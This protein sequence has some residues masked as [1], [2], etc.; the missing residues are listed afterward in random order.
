MYLFFNFA[1][2]F[3]LFYSQSHQI[4]FIISLEQMYQM[5]LTKK[6][7]Q[8]QLNNKHIWIRLLNNNVK[9]N[10]KQLITLQVLSTELKTLSQEKKFCLLVSQFQ[11]IVE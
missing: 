9:N 2:D 10:L 1:T 5:K 6:Q 4:Q 3:I 8:T 11:D 7:C